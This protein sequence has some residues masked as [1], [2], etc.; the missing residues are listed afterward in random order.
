MDVECSCCV[1]FRCSLSNHNK[2]PF[3]Q[4]PACLPAQVCDHWILC[5]DHFGA[6]YDVNSHLAIERRSLSPSAHYLDVI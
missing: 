3:A 4:V 2:E 5:S 6:F 1:A